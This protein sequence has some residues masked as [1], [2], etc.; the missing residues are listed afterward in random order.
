[1]EEKEEYNISSQYANIIEPYV[2][3]MGPYVS[4]NLSIHN[5]PNTLFS[6]G[7][8]RVKY[9][10]HLAFDNPPMLWNGK[11][12]YTPIEMLNNIEYD[13]KIFTLTVLMILFQV[14]GD[15]NHRTAAK[16]FRDKVGRNLTPE[17]NNLINEFHETNKYGSYG[18]DTLL[19]EYNPIKEINNV[20]KKI[21]GEYRILHHR[22]GGK[23]KNKRRKTK[24]KKRIKSG[25]KIKTIKFYKKK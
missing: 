14:F 6:K 9:W 1:M 24:N 2:D 5:N 13:E 18:Y 3:E 15:G 4:Y 20:V 21:V 7:T 10:I 8:D 23:S 12:Y 25:R 16:F 17:E 19:V 22:R 11:N